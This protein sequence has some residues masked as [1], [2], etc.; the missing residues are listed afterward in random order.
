M[1]SETDEERAEREQCER[2][3]DRMVKDMVGECPTC[4]GCDGNVG[5][6]GPDIGYCDTHRL[7]WITGWGN[8]K[9][10]HQL[11]NAEVY[12]RIASYTNSEAVQH[13]IEIA[14]ASGKLPPD[15]AAAL[16]EN[17]TQHRRAAGA[18]SQRRRSHASARPASA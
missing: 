9:H 13:E 17:A 8:F 6:T 15:E 16:R 1:S 3:A 11:N 7:T 5:F 4:G 14:L 18:S 10:W 2:W 12:R